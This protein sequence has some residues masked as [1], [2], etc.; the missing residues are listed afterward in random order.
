[1]DTDV[2]K[3]E[4]QETAA[5]AADKSR[6][7]AESASEQA[8][9]LAGTAREQA[10]EVGAEVAHQ[11]RQVLSQATTKLHEQGRQ[12]THA[13]ASTVRGWADQTRALADGHPEQAGQIAGYAR[14]AADRAAQAAGT[15]EERGFDGI[16]DDVQRFARRRPGVFLLGAA[17]AGFGA[18]R[19]IRSAPGATEDSAPTV[20]SRN[21][22]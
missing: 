17:I 15:L 4:V 3:S 19:L 9:A 16:V 5:T 1:M 2:S 7:V 13:L 11:G 10:A 20:A 6:E 8:G 12:Q 14:D 18:G 22:F 21:G